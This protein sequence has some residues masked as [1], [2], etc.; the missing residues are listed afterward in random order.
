MDRI[1]QACSHHSELL[2]ARPHVARQLPRRRAQ[3]RI[4]PHLRHTGDR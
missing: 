3:R 1:R 4:A 2:D